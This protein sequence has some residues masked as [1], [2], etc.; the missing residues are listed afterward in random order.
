M[1][2]QH[3]K[4]GTHCLSRFSLQTLPLNYISRPLVLLASENQRFKAEGAIL[5]DNWMAL[6]SRV[7]PNDSPNQKQPRW[8][9][10]ELMFATIWADGV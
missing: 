10:P 3:C 2:V 5:W 1:G 4:G 9:L 8:P 6:P 7:T